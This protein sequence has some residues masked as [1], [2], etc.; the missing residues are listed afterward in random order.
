MDAG[1]TH[2]DGVEFETT[3]LREFRDHARALAVQAAAEE[4]RDMAAAACLEVLGGPIGISSSQYGGRS[5]HGSGWSGS[6][7]MM[8][9][10]VFVDSDSDSGGAPGTV[11]LGRISVT[12]SV[13]MEVCLQFTGP[14][15]SLSW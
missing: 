15:S 6:H 7:S 5:W 8:A 2:I 10:N 13:S 9:Q 14:N 12:A 1:A 4:A 11:T 3:K